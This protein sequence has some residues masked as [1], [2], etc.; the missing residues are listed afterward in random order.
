MKWFII[1]MVLPLLVCESD[2][3][4]LDTVELNTSRNE[5]IMQQEQITN[6][7][8]SIKLDIKKLIK[9]LEEKQ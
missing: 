6:D 7:L 8:D 2:S 4:L 1:V 9:Q 3:S 5:M